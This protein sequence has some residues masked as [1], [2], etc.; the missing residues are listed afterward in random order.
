MLGRYIIVSLP[1]PLSFSQAWNALAR[2]LLAPFFQCPK[3]VNTRRSVTSLPV[4]LPFLYILKR[5]PANFVRISSRRSIP[6]NALRP[7]L[8]HRA[9]FR[10]PPHL[11]R[12]QQHPLPILL[13]F[14]AVEDCAGEESGR[15]S[16]Q[17]GQGDCYGKVVVC[18]CNVDGLVGVQGWGRRL[19]GWLGW[20]A[21]PGVLCGYI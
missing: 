18:I 20:G 4:P 1:I 14:H 8:P 2:L 12:H 21:P 15:E 19:E 9:Q 6:L 5:N 3:P 10:H 13:L 17:G 11:V 7:P 16:G